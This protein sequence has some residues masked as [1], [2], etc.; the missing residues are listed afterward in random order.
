[1]PE[2]VSRSHDVFQKARHDFI[3]LA[4]KTEAL[5]KKEKIKLTRQLKRAN[6]RV[7]KEKDRLSFAN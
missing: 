6:T 1:M 2:N 5:L 4:H 3:K 7:A